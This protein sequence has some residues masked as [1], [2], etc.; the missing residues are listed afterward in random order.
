MS[1]SGTSGL[2]GSGTGVRRGRIIRAARTLFARNGYDSTSLEA[3]GRAVGI[4]GPALYRHFPS[5]D[6]LFLATMADGDEV[7]AAITADV[8]GHTPIEALEII[9][10]GE[11]TCAV[12]HRECMLIWQRD[13]HR[14]PPI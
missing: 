13:R 14:M 2:Q 4:T 5:K 10:R 1:S 7:A 8:E 12:K 11:A 9:L 6:A 3:V